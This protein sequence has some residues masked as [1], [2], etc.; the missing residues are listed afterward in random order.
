MW[1]C[2]RSGVK[3]VSKVFGLSDWKN[4]VA[5]TSTGKMTGG[6]GWRPKRPGVWFGAG[7]VYVVYQAL[8]GR[9]K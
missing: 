3:D 7:W 6:A 8:N 1:G 4:G 9:V 5:I 2:D